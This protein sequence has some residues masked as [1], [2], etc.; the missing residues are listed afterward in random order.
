MKIAIALIAL[1]LA[2]AAG[3]VVDLGSLGICLPSHSPTK[4]R[5]TRLGRLFRDVSAT[6]RTVFLCGTSNV[7]AHPGKPPLAIGP[8]SPA[9]G[10]SSA[11]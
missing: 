11:R 5:P 9:G 2:L 7:A 3:T 8:G 10:S 4:S 6:Q 1:V